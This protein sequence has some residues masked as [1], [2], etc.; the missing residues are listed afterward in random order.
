MYWLM[1][2]E[3]DE[4]GVEHLKERP[5]RTASWDGVRNYQARNFLRS[6]R[7]GDLAFFYH[8]SCPEPGI[9]A[10]IKILKQAY[11]D[12][13][14]WDKKSEY[15]DARSTPGKPVWDMVDVQ[16][17]RQLKRPVLLAEIKRHSLLKK[18]QLVQR[19]NRLSVMPVTALE[20]NAILKLTDLRK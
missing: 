9:A 11:P 6:M 1:K 20:W 10:I 19:G 2:S 4:F 18:M 8:S 5:G 15:F 13:S 3:P 7:R 14:A 17:V 16:L 12:H